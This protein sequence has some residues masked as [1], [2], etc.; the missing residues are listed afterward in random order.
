MS[1]TDLVQQS[2]TIALLESVINWEGMPR[3]DRSQ[4]PVV[5]PATTNYALVGTAF[6]Y[7]FRFT[8]QADH[9][10]IAKT[11][12]WIATLSLMLLK[13]EARYDSQ[14]APF[15]VQVSELIKQAKASHYQ[16]L[17]T[18]KLEPDLLKSCIYLAQIDAYYRR[19][20]LPYNLGQ[21]DPKDVSDLER[22]YSVI[23]HP[24][25]APRR[26]LWLNPDFGDASVLVAGADADVILDSTIIDIKTSK[27]FELKKEYLYQLIGY[28][29]LNA[30]SHRL[31]IKNIAL[32]FSRFATLVTIPIDQIFNLKELPRV[33]KEFVAIARSLF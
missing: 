24:A 29:I 3:L 22:L 17:V 8:L 27:Y 13:E 5:P 28:F 15:V 26:I 6:D 32:Y 12:Q 25:F 14:L 1:L 30:L 33:C 10:K 20:E 16:Y 23:P 19:A 4:K 31:L 11:S 18:R 2:E 21:A 9:L 7:L